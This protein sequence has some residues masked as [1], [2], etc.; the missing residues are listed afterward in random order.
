MKRRRVKH[1]AS[2]E[3]RL[4]TEARRLRELAKGL[5]PGSIEREQLIRKARQAD[6]AVHM[7]EWL[8]SPGLTSPK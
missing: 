8:S 5:Q 4:A 3:E 7:N 6:T 1:Q 2:F